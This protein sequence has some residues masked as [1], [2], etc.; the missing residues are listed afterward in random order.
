MTHLCFADDLLLLCHSDEFSACVL[1][2]AL[3]EF[4]M[5]SCLF[6]SQAKS[7]VFFGSVP[8]TVI[9]KILLALPFST[10]ELPMKYLGIPLTGKRI[11]NTDCRVLIDKVKNR[12]Y[13]WRN[14]TLSFVS[15]L[16]ISGPFL[17]VEISLII[18]EVTI[19]HLLFTDHYSSFYYSSFLES[20]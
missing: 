17:N 7:V 11:R 2:R 14:K 3:D 6:P 13:D 9:S 12:I 18:S 8:D 5:T 20:V 15:L 1:R 10:G 19:H 16:V 4:T